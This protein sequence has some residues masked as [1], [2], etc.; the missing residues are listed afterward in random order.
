M[1]AIQ[2]ALTGGP[3]VLKYVDVPDPKPG[4]GQAL[5]RMRAIGVNYMDV[6][7]RAGT[8]PQLPWIPGGEGAGTV[9]E[10]GE[11]VTEV[12]VGDVVAYANANYSYA[13]K[14]VAPS[15][16]LV[17]TPQGMDPKTCAAAM[18]QGMTAHFLATGTYPLKQGDTC[19]VHAAA[20][21]VGSLL[22][23][24]AKMRG[25]KVVATVS[26]KGKADLVKSLGADHVINYAEQD[27]E[28]ETRRI[29]S[30]KG[31]NVVYDGVGKD[32]FNKSL[33]SLGRRGYLVLYGAASGPVPPVSP[34]VLN[35][36][37]KYLTRPSLGDYTATREELLQRANELLGW[38]KD[39]K[40][41]LIISGTFPLK[42]AAEAHRKMQGRE[43]VGK[44]VLI[45]EGPAG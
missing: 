2:I 20:G 36:G 8:A 4:K 45:P 44:L 6:N 28:E 22:V 26:S 37:S 39:G 32:T 1:K 27:F 18:L 43:T 35:A 16:R 30:G 21:G 19:L 29:T 13:E 41:K 17:K 5:L 7:G 31:V 23:Q 25:A 11:G 14:V 40:L 15:W 9:I 33:A 38:I 42:E 24:I 12:Q 34:T 10:V 3:E